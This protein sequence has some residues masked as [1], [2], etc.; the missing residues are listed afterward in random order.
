M[1]NKALGFWDAKQLDFAVR[2]N[3][4]PSLPFSQMNNDNKA[5]ELQLLLWFAF[6]FAAAPDG[7]FFAISGKWPTIK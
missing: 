2:R 5:I 6:F 3:V 4:A 7:D 1:T